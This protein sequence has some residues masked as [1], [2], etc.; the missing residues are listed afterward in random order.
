MRTT[1]QAIKKYPVSTFLVAS[2]WVACMLPVPETPLNHIS[3]FD[4]WVHFLM[5]GILCCTIWYEYIRCH[6][7]INGK[8]L[9]IWVFVGPVVMGGLVELAQAYLT[10][11][12]RSGDW[13]DFA[14]N[15]IGVCLGNA[16]GL[17]I[18]KILK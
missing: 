10:M 6:Q 5:Y 13:I 3:M 9:F 18:Y 16:V 17:T 7:A 4:K 8:R 12:L 14:A 11:G 1:I 2:I 15:S